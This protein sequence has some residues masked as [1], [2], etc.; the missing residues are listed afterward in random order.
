[1]RVLCSSVGL[2]ALAL[3]CV[4]PVHA[5][6]TF[7]NWSAPGVTFTTPVTGTTIIT[8]N[9]QGA[10]VI[11]FQVSIVTAG[12]T[13][14]VGIVAQQGGIANALQ[15]NHPAPRNTNTISTITIT[16]FGMP[17]SNIS[18]T[19]ADVDR[20]AG[21]WIDLVTVITGGATLTAVSPANVQIT[22]QQAL[23]IG[24][25]VPN[26]S[27]LGNVNVL[28]APVTTSVVFTYKGATGDPFGAN[29]L[30]GISN[31]SFD[32]PEPGTLALLGLGLAAILT[33]RRWQHPPGSANESTRPS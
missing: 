33:R 7:I 2:A 18:F 16:L 27:N 10:M 22:G 17:F 1:M 8:G 20:L 19:I 21:G 6:T 30:I 25:S 29:Q 24:A 28:I 9:T 13:Q 14:Q 11:P 4:T 3:A 26:T 31:I 23:A 12:S 32:I 5:G 15:I